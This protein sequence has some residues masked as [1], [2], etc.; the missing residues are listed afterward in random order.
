MSWHTT[1]RRLTAL[2]S[3][4][5]LVSDRAVTGCG[6]Q[7]HDV[8]RRAYLAAL[9]TAGVA[10]VGGCDAAPPDGGTKTPTPTDERGR[11]VRVGPSG[12]GCPGDSWGQMAAIAETYDESVDD[13]AEAEALLKAVE[14]GDEYHRVTPRPDGIEW[15]RRT[16]YVDEEYEADDWFL[17]GTRNTTDLV[18]VLVVSLD[19][20]G[21]EVVR[22]YVGAC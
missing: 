15:K 8:H 17:F 7:E 13:A 19:G 21:T 1:D 4:S 5:T 22:F 11:T 6:R 12:P 10:S 3:V 20:G 9:A 2:S 18:G 14:G 16:V